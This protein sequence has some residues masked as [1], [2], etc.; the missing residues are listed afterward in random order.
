MAAN[1]I[2]ITDPICVSGISGKSKPRR[3]VGTAPNIKS[4]LRVGGVWEKETRSA[5]FSRGLNGL[6]H[7]GSEGFHRH[8]GQADLHH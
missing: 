7:R 6:L 1:R 5:R 4:C 2:E 3:V 8:E